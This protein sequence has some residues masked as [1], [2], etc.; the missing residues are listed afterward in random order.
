[1]CTKAEFLVINC[2]EIE[3]GHVQ[4][5]PL[6]AFKSL[7]VLWQY[8]F[9][10]IFTFANMSAC[11]WCP[12]LGRLGP[13]KGRRSVPRQPKGGDADA[14]EAT[15]PHHSRR[16]QEEQGDPT[17]QF[18]LADGTPLEGLLASKSTRRTH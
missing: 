7:L 3:I 4:H 18:K 11:D 6:F 17:A 15:A 8:V 5:K 13:A 12:M 16:L 1:M 2:L 14:E 9:R 10:L